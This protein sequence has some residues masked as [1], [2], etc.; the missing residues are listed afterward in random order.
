M[1]LSS[2]IEANSANYQKWEVSSAITVISND[3]VQVPVTLIN[4]CAELALQDF[5]NNESSYSWLL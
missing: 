2:K 5:A 4:I 1:S 3:Y